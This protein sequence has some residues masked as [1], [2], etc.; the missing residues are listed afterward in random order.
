MH[1]MLEIQ[2]THSPVCTTSLP[3]VNFPRNT[4]FL[5]IANTTQHNTWLCTRAL[6]L[7]Q[8]KPAFA[9]PYIAGNILL[10]RCLHRGYAVHNFFQFMANCHWAI[11]AGWVNAIGE[12]QVRR[13]PQSL[14][15]YPLLVLRC[16]LLLYLLHPLL[17]NFFQPRASIHSARTVRLGVSWVCRAGDF[18]GAETL[19]RGSR[20]LL[21]FMQGAAPV[22]ET[23]LPKGTE[24]EV[25]TTSSATSTPSAILPHMANND[26]P[27][28][29]VLHC[30][31]VARDFVHCDF[32][33]NCHWAITCSRLQTF[34]A[35]SCQYT[36]YSRYNQV[37][38]IIKWYNIVINIY[39]NNIIALNNKPTP[40]E[41]PHC[42]CMYLILQCHKNQVHHTKS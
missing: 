26:C 16:Q 34:S 20:L 1:A 42:W 22:T 21:S 13:L 2:F 15:L 32:M 14:S 17:H 23:M 9:L 28:V 18:S 41:K 8:C 6:A 11:T 24:S 37:R 3:L 10:R 39:L 19:V 5:W 40:S 4:E 27:V 31:Y 29:S 35:D 38:S 7:C 36:S 12:F 30:N 25:S 33:A